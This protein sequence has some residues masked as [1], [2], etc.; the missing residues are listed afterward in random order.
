MGRGS[1]QRESVRSGR[2][3]GG[4]SEAG[5]FRSITSSARQSVAPG[6][7]RT[8]VSGLL[9]KAEPAP[10]S[11]LHDME[12]TQRRLRRAHRRTLMPTWLLTGVSLAYVLFEGGRML[13]ETTIQQWSEEAILHVDKEIFVLHDF[14]AGF[15]SLTEQLTADYCFLNFMNAAAPPAAPTV[16]REQIQALIRAYAPSLCSW[17]K[18]LYFFQEPVAALQDASTLQLLNTTFVCGERFADLVRRINAQ[19]VDRIHNYTLGKLKAIEMLTPLADNSRWTP[20]L[21]CDL[22]FSSEDLW[23]CHRELVSLELLRAQ[24]SGYLR[25]EWHLY[26]P[27]LSIVIVFIL[28]T[29]F[30]A[31][32]P[33]FK[34]IFHSRF[35]SLWG[36][37][38]QIDQVLQRRLENMVVVMQSVIDDRMIGRLKVI[39][40]IQSLLL[41]SESPAVMR[42]FFRVMESCTFALLDGLNLASQYVQLE[43]QSST[44]GRE[45][46]NLRLLLDGC[47][48]VYKNETQAKGIVV[49]CHYAPTAPTA[50]AVDKLRLRTVMLQVLRFALLEVQVSEAEVRLAAK[51]VFLG[52][53]PQA[54][55]TEKRNDLK[56]FD[57]QV[58]IKC[59]LVS[60]L[61]FAATEL[62]DSSSLRLRKGSGIGLIYARK[63]LREL[64]G[65]ITITATDTEATFDI[66][67]QAMG[68]FHVKDFHLA[69]GAVKNAVALVMNVQ[70]VAGFSQLAAVAELVGVKLIP[71]ASVAE[72]AE[73]MLSNRGNR[74]VAVFFQDPSGQARAQLSAAVPQ[75][76]S[77][78]RRIPLIEI[79][80]RGGDAETQRQ[81]EEAFRLHQAGDTPRDAPEAS[82]RGRRG[83]AAQGRSLLRDSRVF[84]R[85]K[86]VPIEEPLM[87]SDCV[88][89]MAIGATSFVASQANSRDLLRS[90]SYGRR[91]FWN[92]LVTTF[93]ASAQ[94]TGMSNHSN[95]VSSLASHDLERIYEP[96][97]LRFHDPVAYRL[98]RTMSHT[99]IQNKYYAYFVIDRINEVGFATNV[100]DLYKNMVLDP[101]VA[102]LPEEK[103]MSFYELTQ[104]RAYLLETAQAN[105]CL[106]A[107]YN[108][109]YL[110]KVL[111]AEI[112]P[113]DTVALVKKVYEDFEVQP[114]VNVSD[115]DDDADQ[116][117]DETLDTA[118]EFKWG[119][120][121]EYTVPSCITASVA[122]MDTVLCLEPSLA[123]E[124]RLNKYKENAPAIAVEFIFSWDFDISSL[125]QDMAA[126]LAY[127]LLVWCADK[128]QIRLPAETCQKFVLSVQQNYFA[129]P[130]HNF[131]HAL[132]AAQAV[133]LIAKDL[134]FQQWFSYEDKFIIMLAA[135]G[136]DIGHP[137]VTNE[138][139]ISMR[140]FTS[141]LFNETA[142]LENY[143][144]LL[145]LD[146]L[147][148]P[149]LDILKSL[150]PEAL[151][152]ARQRIIAAILATDKAL[153]MKLI[154]LLNDLKNKNEQVPVPAALLD[155]NIRDACLIHAADHA[156]A[157]LNFPLHRRWSEK[158]AVEMHFQNTMDEALKLPKSYSSL[159]R[160][161]EATLAGSQVLLIDA[162][163]LPFFSTLAW[164][165]PGDLDMRVAVMKA[166]A[167]FWHHVRDE[168]MR[169]TV[170]LNDNPEQED[171]RS[172][173]LQVITSK[174]A[175]SRDKLHQKATE[176]MRAEPKDVFFDPHPMVAS[177][178]ESDGDGDGATLRASMRREESGASASITAR[179]RRSDEFGE[180]RGSAAE[181]LRADVESGEASLHS[182]TEKEGPRP[183]CISN[184]GRGSSSAFSPPSS[185]TSLRAHFADKAPED[186]A[187]AEKEGELQNA[188]VSSDPPHASAAHSTTE[189]GQQFRHDAQ[190]LPG[191]EETEQVA[192]EAFGAI[193]HAPQKHGRQTPAQTPEN[194][195]QARA[196]AALPAPPPA[197][198][199]DSEGRRGVATETTPAEACESSLDRLAGEDSDR[200]AAPPGAPTLPPEASS[201]RLTSQ[202][203]APPSAGEHTGD[204]ADSEPAFFFDEASG[205][206]FD[207][208]GFAY[209][210]QGNL[211]GYLD[212]S[213]AFQ[214]YTKS[215]LQYYA[216]AMSQ[217]QEAIPGVY[218]V[219]GELVTQSLASQTNG[220]RADFNPESQK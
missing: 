204:K 19:M 70:H 138:F 8:T 65:D 215:E 111:G 36:M 77:S 113:L 30:W 208:Q 136:H 59:I 60:P 82:N 33:V 119:S 114:E 175:E 182:Q 177:D 218:T 220:A 162:H 4:G 174:M 109:N 95:S 178:C 210:P 44:E 118:E 35:E 197:E 211:R 189:D 207:R 79:L 145:Y 54:T 110:S 206:F 173:K 176:L 41:A 24:L 106:D 123:S 42:Q 56:N 183:V 55:E 34:A 76:A 186:A 198:N 98:F 49:S 108:E 127:E 15:Y 99:P 87:S 170:A 29:L 122:R 17:H 150:P 71:V 149:E 188:A 31:R 90:L 20:H 80:P 194:A 157:L 45:M 10:G 181:G 88:T 40:G 11:D 190:V 6:A 5:H 166:N 32:R 192:D 163:Y 184:S 101:R 100:I 25:R 203:V 196:H 185:R 66:F 164:Y 125:Q 64:N 139:L 187:V 9:F 43:M 3:A 75:A 26:S 159:S 154:D 202:G 158:L 18:D 140:S 105:E 107:D 179:R 63:V 142:V 48:Q 7:K 12:A 38:Q 13:Y 2:G 193:Q 61:A 129:L 131:N 47:I 155:A 133:I 165:F 57:L 67:F 16:T 146:L 216:D 74:I 124:A 46:T 97:V 180:A 209:D 58:S 1:R 62:L 172:A 94:R 171:W 160:L 219:A 93:S 213:G 37:L 91:S 128:A 205:L 103:N 84:Q 121:P 83:S 52:K 68:R 27:I 153:D 161:S 112:A 81:L 195:D 134:S 143:H 214:A 85:A 132:H 117:E 126:K 151:Q 116:P 201:S 137:G 130:F 152:R 168:E 115:D 104:T 39:S 72:A 191:E 73:Q 199:G 217:M 23:T 69:F 120:I 28:A 96:Q 92:T 51:K 21:L 78:A 144:T 135:L 212:S 14:A 89:A 22:D 148:N 167:A 147:K 86:I 200:S 50:I 53:A 102:Q 156:L 169:K 141:I